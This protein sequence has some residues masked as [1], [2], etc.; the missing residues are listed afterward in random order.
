MTDDYLAVYEALIDGTCPITA[1]AKRRWNSRLQ[2]LVR[3]PG[4]CVHTRLEFVQT[5]TVSAF[6]ID[7]STPDEH[8]RPDD[9]TLLAGS[10]FVIADGAGD[11]RPTTVNGWA[12][13]AS[14]PVTPA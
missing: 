2:R 12:R 8:S 9:V 4:R 6:P 11:I 10:S 3:E 7:E 1:R 5:G 13:T 14:T